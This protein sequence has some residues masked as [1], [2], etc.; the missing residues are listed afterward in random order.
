MLFLIL[1]SLSLSL[2]SL[3]VSAAHALKATRIPLP[4]K[5]VIALISMLLFGSAVFLGEKASTFFSPHATKIIGIILML[6]ICTWMLLQVLLN[7]N[8]HEEPKTIL[9]FSMKSLGL[10]FQIIRNP[11]LSDMDHSHSISPIEAVFLGL[12][13]SI[14]S[15]SVGIGYSLIGS[16]NILAPVFVGVFQLAFLY[17][18]EIIGNRVTRFKNMNTDYLQLISVAVMFIL[19]ILR[20]INC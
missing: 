3:A 12:A 2:D 20:V 17:L 11:L 13:L 15:I 14:D 16:V 1:L 5:L 7:K 8:K 6:L 10:T 9:H 19:L 18:G 4:S